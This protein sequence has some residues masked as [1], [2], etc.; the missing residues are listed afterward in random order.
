ME[1]NK[2][3]TKRYFPIARAGVLISCC[4][5]GRWSVAADCDRLAR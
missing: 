4:L 3:A 2:P 1:G 5:S